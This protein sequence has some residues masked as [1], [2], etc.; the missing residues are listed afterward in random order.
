MADSHSHPE[1]P[2]ATSTG[3]TKISTAT[4]TAASVKARLFPW[5]TP[6]AIL[7]IWYIAT[8]YGWAN[9][10]FMPSPSAVAE[11]FWNRLTQGDLIENFLASCLRG[12]IGFAAGASVGFF[13]GF[14]NGGTKLAENMFD[15]TLQM[16][17]NIPHLALM[18]LVILW[19]GIG[20]SGKQFLVALG[21]FFPVYINTFHGIR[22]VSPDLIEMGRSYGLNGWSLFH[23]IILPGALPSILVG[24]RYALGFTWLTLVVAVMFGTDKGIG[25]M[26]MD[27]REFM[28]APTIIFSILI[29]AVMGKLADTLVRLMEHYF[30]GWNKSFIS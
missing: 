2:R 29:F 22:S 27:A 23:E 4:F 30:T 6:L 16:L 26:A 9:P 18:P 10:R 24:V 15:T 19:F 11:A 7:A 14:I 28:D 21:V 17:R 13:F 20:E 3:T 12:G 5:L 8:R 1:T 25:K